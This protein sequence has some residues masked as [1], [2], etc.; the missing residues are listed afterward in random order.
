MSNF[1][2][3]T[4]YW[5]FLGGCGFGENAASI[6]DAVVLLDNLILGVHTGASDSGEFGV[7]GDTRAVRSDEL[8]GCMERETIYSG[9]S[10]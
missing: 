3:E 7:F 8:I 6:S 2:G 1:G 9:L 4:Q 10:S 5:V